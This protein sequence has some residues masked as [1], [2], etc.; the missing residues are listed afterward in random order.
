[1]PIFFTF[2]ALKTEVRVHLSL[3]LVSLIYGATFSMA[4]VVMPAYLEPFG[5][6]LLRVASACLLFLLFHRLFVREK[7]D[8]GDLLALAT[9]AFFGVALNML[10]FFKGLAITSPVN[11]SVLMLVTPVFVLLL[12]SVVNREK[13]SWWKNLGVGLAALG[14]LLLMGGWNF[15]FSAETVWGDLYIILNALSYAVYLV[16]VKRLMVKYHP[17][18]VSKWNFIFGLLIVLP[19]GWNDLMAVEWQTFTGEAWAIVAFILVGTTFLTY[20]LNAWALQHASSSLVGSYIYLQPVVA[21]VLAQLNGQD[22]L[23]F[24][25]ICF[26]LLIFAGV[27]LVSKKQK[28]SNGN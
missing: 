5:F 8:K 26:I 28:S 19:F 4:K 14:A 16:Y 17:V 25:K 27:Y 2:E 11:G 13:L 15:R 3:F 22:Q 21:T 9:S 10:L 12:S 24:E 20:L 6:I 18:T 23:N 1:M 7:V